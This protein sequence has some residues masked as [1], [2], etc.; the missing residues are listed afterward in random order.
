MY[1]HYYEKYILTEKNIF[2]FI[3]FVDIFIIL[4][5]NTLPGLHSV[6]DDLLNDLLLNILLYITHGNEILNGPKILLRKMI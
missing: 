5:G 1:D 2:V 3:H 4:Y 6:V